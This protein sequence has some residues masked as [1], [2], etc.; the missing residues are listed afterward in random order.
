MQN[1]SIK[2]ETEISIA[3][4]RLLGTKMIRKFKKIEWKSLKMNGETYIIH[5]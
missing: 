1:L 4:S 3:H 2:D 5:S